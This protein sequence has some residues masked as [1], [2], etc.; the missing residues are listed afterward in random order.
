MLRTH[1]LKPIDD[2]LGHSLNLEVV[3]EFVADDIEYGLEFG[4]FVVG[5]GHGV[6]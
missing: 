4:A 1:A 3:D 5:D 2:V 6:V